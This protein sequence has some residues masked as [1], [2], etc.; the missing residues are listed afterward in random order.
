MKYINNYF[1]NLPYELICYI[2]SFIPR[3]RP[4]INKVIKNNKFIIDMKK[5][6]KF[7]N[8]SRENI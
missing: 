6:Y 5:N 4:R 3:I 2:F 1:Y 8:I 7:I